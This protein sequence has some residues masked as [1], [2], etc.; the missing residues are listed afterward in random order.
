MLALFTAIM[1]GC[2]CL[3]AYA[4]SERKGEVRSS[5]LG[6]NAEGTHFMVG[7]MQ[8]EINDGY[9]SAYQTL[10]IASRLSATVTLISPEGDTTKFTLQP[11]QVI[12]IAVPPEYECH[13]EGVEHNGIEILSTRPISVYG[14]SS[15]VQTSEGYLALPINSWGTSYVTACYKL[16][17]YDYDPKDGGGSN[18][19]PR[20]GE[21]AVIAAEDNTVVTVY[22]STKTFGGAAKGGA[23]SKTLNKGDI[24]QVQDGGEYRGYSD[25]SGSIVTS[26]KPVGVLSG[27]VRAAVPYVYNT[28]DHLIEMLPPVNA[29]GKQ[30]IVVP[31]GGRM[32]GDQ[33]RVVSADVSGVSVT[34]ANSTGSTTRTLATL[35]DYTDWDLQEVTAITA[36]RPIL[37]VQYSKSQGADPRNT[38][39]IDSNNVNFDPNMV[40]ITPQEQFVNAAVFQTLPNVAPNSNWNFPRGTKQFDHHFVTIVAE[41]AQ[42]ASLQIDGKQLAL[43]PGIISGVVPTLPQY[44]WATFEASDGKVH[45]IT[46]DALF[47]GYVY[48]LG[49]ADS[50][51]WPVGSGLRK[52]N[53]VDK[54]APTLAVRKV[55]GAYEITAKDSGVSESGLLAVRLDSAASTN[56]H[57][58]AGILIRG[59]EMSLGTISLVDPTKSGHARI[60]AEDLAH[61][62]DTLELD[63]TAA[64]LTFTPAL[65]DISPVEPNVIDRRVF[66][67]KNEGSDPIVID[68]LIL[69]KG[70]P[71][72]LDPYPIRGYTLNPG[73]S[74]Q[75]TVY[76]YSKVARSYE[77]TVIFSAAC[78]R[79][80]IPVHAGMVVPDIVTHDLDFGDLRLE[81]ER[82]MTLVVRNTGLGSLRIDSVVFASGAF[83][84]PDFPLARPIEVAGGDSVRFTICFTPNDTLDFADS[85]TFY[86]NADTVVASHLKGRGI[87]PRLT[88]TGY[89]FGDV[90]IGDTTCASVIIANLG[91]DT[92]H[93]T[94]LSLAL[95][96]GF[97]PDRGALPADIPPGDSLWLRVCFVPGAEQLYQ[98]EIIGRRT[99]VLTPE[100]VNELRGSGYVLIATLD[101]CDWR[102]RDISSTND[103]IIYVVNRADHPIEIRDVQLWAGD[104]GDF[105]VDPLAAAVMLGVGDSLPVNAR[106][107]PTLP[108][109]RSAL[110]IAHTSARGKDS[111][112]QGL[113]SGFALIALSHDTAEFDA[114]PM[115]SCDLR[116]GHVTIYNDGNMPLT[117]EAIALQTTPPLVTLNAP[118]PG[119]VIPEGD[120][121]VIDF[122]CNLGGYQG[123][124]SWT[125]SW[126]FKEMPLQPF[127]RAFTVESHEQFYG[128]VAITPRQVGIGDNFDLKVSVDSVFWRG[129]PQGKV[130]LEVL[131]NPTIAHFDLERWQKIVAIAATDPNA[132]WT[133]NGN[134]LIDQAGKVVLEFVPLRNLEATLDSVT[135]LTLPFRGYLGNS[136]ADTLRV[137]MSTGQSHCVPPAVAQAPYQLDSICGLATRLF[138]VTGDAY[139]LNQN[140][141]NPSSRSTDITF[142]LGMEAQTR[143]EVFSVDGRLIQILIDRTLP[144][145]DYTIPFVTEG[146]ASGLYYY[147]LVSGP[148][149]AMRSMLIAK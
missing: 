112:I 108:G 46:G 43:Q 6:S 114:R 130:N 60:I 105:H 85:V 30:Y 98:T 19:R 50:Y 63:I 38:D 24:F 15:K 56:A 149:S 31:Y 54:N 125:I 100:P 121:L 120:S 49:S 103:S 124:T 147:R 52:T 119:Y 22:P 5:L 142:T 144:A 12:T 136:E 132:K 73:A 80:M 127:E 140:T 10:Q 138:E 59:D 117:L 26:N 27:H 66:T 128:I 65:V 78:Q 110:V 146:Q 88:I 33:I 32:G 139:K 7:F 102:R 25:L 101:S 58:D 40:V 91:S 44:Q 96:A 93:L 11:Y 106:F 16:D 9:Y 145:G 113:L 67:I 89:D 82:C 41:R 64:K 37:V 69:L 81:T 95:P 126:S 21:F 86:S 107:S 71:F 92:A 28:K 129:L 1:L 42:F 111:V 135:F 84:S 36:N 75:V 20:R 118:A 48:G 2:T 90:Q 23:Y 109:L 35:G 53:V 133:A 55:C 17:Q 68:S 116:Q 137:T 8:N 134:P 74:L 72:S 97:L 76:F 79:Y 62:L 123:V 77:D 87:Y 131:Y 115:Y 51:A 45:V 143:L 14:F 29:L 13:D 47:G 4:Q 94:D 99:D 122:I 57:F 70:I 3:S 104:F 83:S 34:F 18:L 61:N 148:Y 141:P 39:T